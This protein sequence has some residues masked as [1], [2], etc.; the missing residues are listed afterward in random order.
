MANTNKNGLIN[1]YNHM[2][3]NLHTIMHSVE[4][5]SRDNLALK[6]KYSRDKIH[7]LNVLSSDEIEKIAGYLQKDIHAAGNYLNKTKKE[8]RDWL[9]FDLEIA[10]DKMAQ[11]FSSIVDQSR[12]ELQQMEQQLHEWHSGEVTGIGTLECISCG[13]RVMF[14]ETEFI[15]ECAN[16]QGTVFQKDFELSSE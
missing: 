8:L 4:R 13:H 6:L 7:K 3:K 1:A 5:G 11:M 9:S 10:E 16:C 2:M 15:P 12:V 14:T